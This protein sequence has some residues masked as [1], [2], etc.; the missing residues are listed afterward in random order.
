MQEDAQSDV[1]KSANHQVIIGP[2]GSFKHQA[3][4]TAWP[5]KVGLIGRPELSITNYQSTLRH[6]S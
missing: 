5:L 1:W 3:V 2:K 4:W 6:I